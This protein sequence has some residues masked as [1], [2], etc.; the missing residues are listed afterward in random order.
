MDARHHDIDLVPGLS[1]LWHAIRRLW[2]MHAL[3]EQ[4]LPVFQWRITQGFF[5]GL[6]ERLRFGAYAGLFR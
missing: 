6:V 4:L 2:H 3:L 1:E 5:V